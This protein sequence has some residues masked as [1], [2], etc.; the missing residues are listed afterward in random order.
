MDIPISRYVFGYFD[1]NIGKW[2]ICNRSFILNQNLDNQ[3]VF[4]Q[5]LSSNW[6]S[7]QTNSTTLKF[8]VLKIPKICFGKKIE[9]IINYQN[10]EKFNHNLIEDFSL[11]SLDQKKVNILFQN[12]KKNDSERIEIV[13]IDDKNKKLSLRFHYLLEKNCL[14]ISLPEIKFNY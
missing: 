4:G 11:F 10:N 6:F 3:V 12:I 1:Q 13:S 2:K 14:V 9:N 7:Y 8:V 5:Y